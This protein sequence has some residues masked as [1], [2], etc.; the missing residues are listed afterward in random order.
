MGSFGARCICYPDSASLAASRSKLEGPLVSL[1]FSVGRL[2]RLRPQ[3]TVGLGPDP[4]SKVRE[5]WTAEYIATNSI[6]ASL[7]PEC[8]EQVKAWI[9]TGLECVDPERLKRP[10]IDKIV[11][12]FNG[13]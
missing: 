3:A 7:D 9:E 6:Y 1:F 11:K 5:K 12:R 4:G 13:S 2:W 8:L 10:S